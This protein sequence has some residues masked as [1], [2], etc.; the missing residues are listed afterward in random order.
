[1]LYELYTV[2]DRVAEE[3]GPVFQSVNT[4]VARRQF[5]QVMKDVPEVDRDS[6]I[7]LFIG[8]YDSERGIITANAVPEQVDLNGTQ[9]VTGATA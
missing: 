9:E 4:G 7:L 1:M 2:L 5:R 8:T 6:Y 3:C